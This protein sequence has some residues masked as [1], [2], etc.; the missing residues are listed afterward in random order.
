MS[1]FIHATGAASSDSLAALP[2]VDWASIGYTAPVPVAV[3]NRDPNAPLAKADV[4]VLTWAPAEWSALDHV[5]LDS[6]INRTRGQKDLEGEWQPYTRKVGALKS[7]SAAYPLWGNYRYVT[8]QGRGGQPITV[9]LF[10]SNTHLAYAPFL[11]GLATITRQILRETQAQWIYSIGTAGGGRLDLRLGDS[12]IT[13]AACLRLANPAN[14]ASPFNNV[15]FTGTGFPSTDLLKPVEPLLIPMNTVITDTELAALLATLHAKWPATSSL[16]LADLV[17][18]PLRPSNIGS[19]R[20]L[21][22]PGVPLLST[23]VFYIATG[24]DDEKWCGLEMDDAVIACVAE[25]EERRYAFV[26][27]ISNPVVPMVTAPGDT[28]VRKHWG[29]LVYS[30][31]GLHTSYNGALVTWALVTATA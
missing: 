31:C 10:Q 3:A 19:P 23:D 27:N 8:L 5:F 22:M 6:A 25:Q 20:A 12:V 26:R 30:R 1:R 17:N 2:I 4:V 29:S 18:D 9:L 14:E 7:E 11:D 21:A 24:P 13:N 28:D 16:T 15:T